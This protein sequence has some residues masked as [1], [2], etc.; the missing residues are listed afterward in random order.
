MKLFDFTTVILVG[1]LMQSQFS[2]ANPLED[3]DIP[4]DLCD[5]IRLKGKCKPAPISAEDNMR[6]ESIEKG[7]IQFTRKIALPTQTSPRT[8]AFCEAYFEISYFQADD[9]IRVNTEI[10]NDTC[11]ASYGDYS[12]RVRTIDRSGESLTRTF[13]E[14]WTRQEEGTV[15]ITKNYP[16]EGDQSLVWVRVNSNRKTACSC[17]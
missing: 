4:V 14:S 3:G 7:Q 11:A 2:Y 17:E 10:K 15:R 13:F 16:M 12:L 6:T 9:Q 5:S 1:V 8:S